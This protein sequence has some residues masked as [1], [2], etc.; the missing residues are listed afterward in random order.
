MSSKFINVNTSSN[1]VVVEFCVAIVSKK[2]FQILN[3]FFSY[4]WICCRNRRRS[5]FFHRWRYSNKYS[6]ISNDKRN[7]TNTY[8]SIN[9]MIKIK[10]L[11]FFT[12]W[13]IFVFT[14][15]FEFC[16]LTYNWNNSI[17][18]ENFM[19][20]ISI[21]F[22]VVIFLIV[23]FRDVMMMCTLDASSIKYCKSMYNRFWSSSML[24]ALF[25]TI[26]HRFSLSWNH[27]LIASITFSTFNIFWSISSDRS[28]NN[29]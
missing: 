27:Y 12:I 1:R 17:V 11:N 18:F 6:R 16:I 29:R 8:D 15:D 28:N 25:I 19:F 13:F 21:V 26:N 14:F 23:K 20:V 5:N 24:F 22:N 9:V 7:V 2:I 10:H 4:R 3:T